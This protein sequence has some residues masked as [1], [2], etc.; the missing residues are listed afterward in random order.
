MLQW[1]RENDQWRWRGIAGVQA[2]FTTRHGGS[3]SVPYDTMN[4]SFSVGDDPKT[5]LENRRRAVPEGLSRLVMAQQVHGEEVAWV[6]A[7]QAGRG[8]LDAAT[9][10]PGL[11]GLLTRD[12]D[13]V[14]GMGFAD[15]VPIFMA[16]VKGRWIGICH[17]GWRGTVLGVQRQAVAAVIR[18]GYDIDDIRVGIGPS[19]G[20]CCYEVDRMVEM[21]VKNALGHADTLISGKDEDHWQLDLWETN[22]LVLESMGVAPQHITVLGRCTS[23]HDEFFSYRRDQKITGRMGGFI[24]RT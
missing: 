5:V 2:W 9:S 6:G 19:I 8:A 3:G 14:L 15:C 4:L 11:D 21:S 22:R 1:V 23:C 7:A 16:D 12:T 24:C 17:A 10:L 18:D 13:L 20:P